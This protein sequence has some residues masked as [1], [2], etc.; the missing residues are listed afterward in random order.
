MREK[1]S[2]S[3]VKFTWDEEMRKGQWQRAVDVGDTN[4]GEISVSIIQL[5]A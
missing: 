5:Y 2:C 1:S 4:G 3:H